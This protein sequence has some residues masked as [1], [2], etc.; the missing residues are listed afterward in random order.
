MVEGFIST[1]QLFFA[2]GKSSCSNFVSYLTEIN[3]T[4]FSF[5]KN[6]LPEKL[7]QELLIFGWPF[8]ASQKIDPNSECA[9]NVMQL[10]HI[11][12]SV[13]SDF[14]G[15]REG[16]GQ[17]EPSLQCVASLLDPLMKRFTFHFYGDKKTNSLEK[18]EWYLTQIL[19]WT[20]IHHDFLE[21]RI[22]SAC[23]KSG[24]CPSVL[25]EFMRG[26]V[27]L[28]FDKVADDLV[29]VKSNPSLFSHLVDE[30]VSFEIEMKGLS[31]C[32]YFF[33]KGTRTPK[34]IRVNERA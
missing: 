23:D 7:N 31:H 25:V 21:T 11:M 15:G 13:S 18:P 17:F 12:T 6:H 33:I 5:L 10:C 9:S 1:G 8:E 34:K 4:W 3:S 16:R 29:K 30:I 2:V 28:V 20:K 32:I 24:E 22:Q 26:L 14:E 19:Q 27:G